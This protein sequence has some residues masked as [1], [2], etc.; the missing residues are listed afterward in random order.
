MIVGDGHAGVQLADSLRT[1]GWVGAITL[2]GEDPDHPYQKPPLSKELSGGGRLEPLPLRGP[3]FFAE[4]RIDHLRRCRVTEIDRA[5][6]TVRLDGDEHRST[7]LRYDRLILA[8][9][10][11]NR[12][13]EVPGCRI[14]GVV[15]LR[16]LADA[17]AIHARLAAARSVVVIGAGFIGLEFAAAARSLGIEVTVLGRGPRVLR[18]SVTP[19]V[20]Q[21]LREL[22][23]GLGTRLVD[24]EEIARFEPRTEGRGASVVTLAGRRYDADLVLVAVGVEPRSELAAAA[25][26]EVAGGIVVDAE[27]RTADPRI[28]A[29]GDCAAF[30]VEG[31]ARRTRVES[32]QNAT[33]QARYLARA[34]VDPSRWEGPP[35]SASASTVPAPIVPTPA[36]AAYTE[37]PWFWSQQGGAKLQIAG[38]V[39]PAGETVVRGD[40]STGRFSVFSFTDAG[41]QAVESVNRPAD[42]LA[43]RRILAGGLRLTA[44][45]A[46]DESFDLKGFSLAR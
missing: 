21:Y 6:R 40:P 35:T 41:L 42:H 32:V 46:A 43:A 38:L 10:A 44:A 15:Q 28:F 45:D 33:G 23:R 34:L 18:R 4:Q 37:V 7:G 22:H 27:L 39:A 26:L 31:G 2:V 25:G 20:E 8:T 36:V 14:D 17:A 5:A 9:G 3:E 12:A 30:P 13:L 24:H 11:E 16:T 1:E 19:P 29:I